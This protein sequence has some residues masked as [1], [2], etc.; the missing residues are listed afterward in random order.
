MASP[1]F[2]F[3][4][5]DAKLGNRDQFGHYFLIEIF[6]DYSPSTMFWN[7]WTFHVNL[8][9]FLDIRDQYK[10]LYETN[11]KNDHIF[12]KP[13][14]TFA[15]AATCYHVTHIGQSAT[16]IS[17]SLYQSKTDFVHL[18]SIASLNTYD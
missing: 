11:I 10:P 6:A 16:G 9:W 7:L 1:S 8:A 5:V 12:A 4:L 17:S 2:H 15:M 14:P 18:H 13:S 3:Y